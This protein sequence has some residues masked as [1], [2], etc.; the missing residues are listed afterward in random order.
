MLSHQLTLGAEPVK[1][2]MCRPFVLNFLDFVTLICKELN[3]GT[4]PFLEI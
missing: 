3:S 2:S 4:L 1:L